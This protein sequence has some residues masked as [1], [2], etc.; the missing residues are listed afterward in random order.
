[1]GRHREKVTACGPLCP[2]EEHSHTGSG[3]EWVE[4]KEEPQYPLAQNIRLEN[5]GY[6]RWLEDTLRPKLHGG[7]A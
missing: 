7:R 2:L 3:L 4:N 5:E 6:Q 1:M